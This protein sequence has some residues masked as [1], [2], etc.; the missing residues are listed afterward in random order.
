MSPVSRP[1]PILLALF[2]AASG[3][4]QLPPSPAATRSTGDY[5]PPEISGMTR[6]QSSD[7]RELVE[8][9]VADREELVRFYSVNR[10]AL[11]LRRLREFYAAWGRRLEAMPYDSLGTEG[12]VDWL[13]MARQL[14][15]CQKLLDRD[16]SRGRE[17]S[18]VIPFAG[19]I[20]R[21]QESRRLMEP[22][23]P[24]GAAA[25]LDR[26]LKEVADVRAALQ[27]GMRSEAPAT[28]KSSKAAEPLTTTPVAAYRSIAAIAELRESLGDWYKF[29]NGYDPAF[30][31]WARASHDRLNEALDGYVKFLREKIIGIEPGKDEPIIG[32]PIGREGLDVELAHEMI[33][34]SPEELLAIASR[35]LA[36]CEAEL[37]KASGEMGFGDNWKAAMEKV[38]ED[39]LAPGGQPGLVRDLALEAVRFVQERDLVTVPPLAA[40]FWRIEMLSPDRQKVAPFFLGG[41]DILVAFPTDAMDYDEKV[42]SLRANNVHFARA[43]VFHELIPGHH[44]QYYYE[45]RLN[46][47]RA[48]FTTPFWVEGWAVWWEFQFWDLGFPK[49]AE[50]RMGMLFWRAHRCARIIFSLNFQLGRWTPQ[51]CVDFL[52]ERVGHERASAAGEVRRSFNGTFPPMYQAG[53]MLGALQLR[54]LHGEM[55]RAGGMTNRAFHDEI[56][57]GGPMPIEMVRVR[58]RGEKPPRDFKPQWRFA[59]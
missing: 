25:T 33:A 22:V 59:D 13:L 53:Y 34:Y 55:V 14:A 26:I 7:L 27:A 48:L 56:L 50:D 24:R 17:M 57:L 30:G 18:P 3:W 54:G 6:P 28:S 15:Y 31:W 42:Q 41:P 11:Q 8:R 51:Q 12:R 46:P 39:H 32:D 29:Y 52:V 35:E 20:A 40:D 47:H 44:L 49:S 45:G 43:T 21:L 38:K 4:A 2:F 37:K 10:S 5:V 1:A 23:D 19:D 16:E 36:W 9:F 58:L